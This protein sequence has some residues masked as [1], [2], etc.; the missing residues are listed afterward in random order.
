MLVCRALRCCWSTKASRHT[1]MW[2]ADVPAILP[3]N[4]AEQVI[5]LVKGTD[6]RYIGLE[7][8]KEE[9]KKD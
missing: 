2:N 1:V 9:L 4:V 5:F 6:V 8:M 3:R 7:R